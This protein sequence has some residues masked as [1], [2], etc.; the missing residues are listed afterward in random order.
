MGRNLTLAPK[1]LILDEPTHG[2][3]VGTKNEIHKLIFELANNGVAILL[4]TSDLPEALA[5][6]DTFV[7]M[8][9]G[10][11]MSILDRQEATEEII[12]RLALGINGHNRRNDEVNILKASLQTYNE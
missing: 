10:R 7:V 5:I 8:H 4:I 3:D 9:E 11:L 6:A 1:L 2:I 12:L